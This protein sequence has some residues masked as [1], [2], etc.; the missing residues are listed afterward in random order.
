[1]RHHDLDPLNLQ[2][3]RLTGEAKYGDELERSLYNHLAA[4]QHPRGDDWCYFTA[5]E[6]RK[7]Y[8][9]GITCCH[10]S[11]PR[12]MALAP[13][14]AYLRGCSGEYDMM[15]GSTDGRYGSAVARKTITHCWQALWKR[16][17]PHWN[18]AARK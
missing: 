11:G 4:A 12:G 2:L 6:G 18:L 9:K 14:T 5:L 17:G 8:D 15:R 10:S 16:R 1:M 3:L 7:V 13:Q